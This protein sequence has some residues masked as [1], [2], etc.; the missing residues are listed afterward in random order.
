MK[1]IFLDVDGVLISQQSG[2]GH[3][4]VRGTREEFGE[5]HWA[6][7]RRILEVTGAKVVVSS[8]W[9]IG[10]DLEELQELLGS[11]VIGRT[12]TDRTLETTRVRGDEIEEWLNEH[13]GVE[14]FVILDDETDMGVLGDYL[15]KTEF[16]TGLLDCHVEE[17]IRRLGEAPKGDNLAKD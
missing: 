11:E 5:D 2:F 16:S 17:C 1:V 13:P 8:T 14:E 7:Y 12:P 4:D 9:R 15:V 10:R 3:Y 6:R